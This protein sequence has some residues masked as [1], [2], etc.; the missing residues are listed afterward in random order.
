MKDG[1]NPKCKECKNSQA[2]R[3][4]QANRD[5]ILASQR[6]RKRDGASWRKVQYGI[7]DEEFYNIV[8]QQQGMCLLGHFPSWGT[9]LVIDHCHKTKKFRGVLCNACNVAI[10]LMK[11]DPDRL[12]LAAEYL[13]K[14]QNGELPER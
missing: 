4:Y 2:R 13:E 3:H 11:D 12:R 1:R 8:S 9:K 5:R 7:T 10:G 6:A 14:F